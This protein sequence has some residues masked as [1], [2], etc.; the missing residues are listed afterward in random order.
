[1]MGIA[2]APSSSSQARNKN[3]FILIW[4]SGNPALV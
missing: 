4:I 1:M 3:F 2:F